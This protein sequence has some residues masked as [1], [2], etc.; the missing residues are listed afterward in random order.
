MSLTN[1]NLSSVHWIR[2][3]LPHNHGW[4]T[5]T[6]T[7]LTTSTSSTN[8]SQDALRNCRKRRGKRN[9]QWLSVEA[10]TARRKRAEK[11]QNRLSLEA[12]EPRAIAWRLQN[13]MSHSQHRDQCFTQS[14]WW[15]CRQPDSD[16]ASGER[17]DALQSDDGPPCTIS[18]TTRCVQVVWR[19]QSLLLW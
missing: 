4:R 17:T 5:C 11:N 19:F 9:S 8:R 13:S 15:G 3:T 14:N 1:W 7:R 18:Q 12:D 2:R 6:W 10:V 16:L